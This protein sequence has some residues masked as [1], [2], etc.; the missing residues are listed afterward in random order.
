MKPMWYSLPQAFLTSASF[1][2]G[3]EKRASGEKLVREKL[4]RRRQGGRAYVGD[5]L[6]SKE[7][8]VHGELDLLDR[9]EACLLQTTHMEK[10]SGR[11]KMKCRKET[12]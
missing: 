4:P 2:C 10:A 8:L 7:G 1:F 12:R 3:G 5:A 9:V 6:D 11:Q